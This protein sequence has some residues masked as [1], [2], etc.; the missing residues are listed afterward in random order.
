MKKSTKMISDNSYKTE[1][2]DSWLDGALIK[3]DAE[4]IG[5]VRDVLHV[6]A[7]FLTYPV[8]FALYEQVV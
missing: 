2:W 4:F 3:F 1:K 6:G 5:G 7:L 8:F